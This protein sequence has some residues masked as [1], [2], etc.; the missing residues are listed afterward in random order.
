[1]AHD[2]AICMVLITSQILRWAACCHYCNPCCHLHALLPAASR[3]CV[4]IF[5]TAQHSG[6]LLWQTASGWVTVNDMCSTNTP[7]AHAPSYTTTV[8]GISDCLIMGQT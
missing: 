1:M 8:R 6:E 7:S 4:V 5:V 3:V 2:E